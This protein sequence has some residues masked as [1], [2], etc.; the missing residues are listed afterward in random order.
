MSLE[1][2]ILFGKE[3]RR[4]YRREKAIDATCR[5]HGSCYCRLH[6]IHSNVLREMIAKEKLIEYMKD[7]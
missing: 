5:N 6:G 4:A 2:A 1:K 7:F 3:Y